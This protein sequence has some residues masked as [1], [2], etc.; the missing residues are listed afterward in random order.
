[1]DVRQ[2]FSSIFMTFA[3]L[4]LTFDV[5]FNLFNTVSKA[6]KQFQRPNEM[7][8]IIIRNRCLQFGMKRC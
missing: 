8:E 1:M 5:I 6:L 4:L 2:I 3:A 7:Q